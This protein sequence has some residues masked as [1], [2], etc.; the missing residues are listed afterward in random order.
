MKTKIY[1]IYDKYF[2]NSIGLGFLIALSTV[3][4][5]TLGEKQRTF[6]S[7]SE[8]GLM[9]VQ[10]ILLTVFTSFVIKLLLKFMTRLRDSEVKT[11]VGQKEYH[12][13]QV[14]LFYTGVIFLFWLPVF[15]AYYPS[16][17]AYDAEG[18]LYQVLA[19]DYSTHHPLIHTLFLGAFF[20]LG[21]NVL[22]SYSAGMAV[23]SIVQM[24]LMAMIFGYTLMVLYQEKTS[25]VMRF[26]LLAFYAIFPTNSILAISTTKDVLF[27]GLVLLFVIK[28]YQWSRGISGNRIGFA[29]AFLS[30]SVLML[31]FRNNAVYAYVVSLPFVFLLWRKNAESVRNRNQNV[32]S[33]IMR[34]VCAVLATLL[35]FVVCSAGLKQMTSA[36]N[37]SP[38]EMLSVPLQQMARTRVHHEEEI[39]A[40]MRTELDSYISSEW[41]FAAYNPYLADPVKSRAVIH[42][43]PVGLIKT[44]V[45]LG[46]QFPMTY[47]DAFLDNSIGYWYLADKSH[48]TIYGVG[49]ESGFGYLSTDNRT[50]P[51]GCEIIE[52][53]YLPGLRVFMEKIVS[54]NEYQ[55]IP[56]LSVIFAPAFYWWLLCLYIVFFFKRK[57]YK[58]LL[59]VVFLVMY[60]LTLLLSP[61]VLIRYMYPFVVSVPV[62]L[63][64]T[65][66]KRCD[67]VENTCENTQEVLKND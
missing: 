21:G 42:D 43:N 5:Y 35:L 22:G 46:T 8:F 7:L 23:H 47:I 59:P 32:K 58:M 62:M 26:I 25:C 3:L 40:A 29:I 6:R 12:G 33:V 65:S 11:R 57:E 15:L 14:F 41:V 50:M 38:R 37:G 36:Y 18:Q 60:Y 28:M 45:K 20:N 34:G 56:V 39:D 27:S 51:A 66:A 54:D 53:S 44:W 1:I 2:K 63:C 4:G 10:V 67:I 61:T 64:L 19:N 52:H 30:I 49:T 48:S 17:F 24:L 16:V 9:V 55:K 31:L 13:W